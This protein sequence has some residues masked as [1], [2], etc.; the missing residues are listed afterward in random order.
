MSRFVLLV[1]SVAALVAVLTEII[2]VMLRHILSSQGLA[3][4]LR[5]MGQ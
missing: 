3:I 2:I 1:P 5:L 4:L